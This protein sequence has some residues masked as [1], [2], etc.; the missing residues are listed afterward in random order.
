MVDEPI[1]ETKTAREELLEYLQSEVMKANRELQRITST[2]DQSRGE[3]EQLAQRNATIMGE[4]RRIEASVD[5]T[6]PL[7]IKE[8]YVEA[9]NSQQA[10]LTMRC[11]MEKLQTQEEAVQGT[12]RSLQAAIDILKRAEQVEADSKNSFDAREMIFRV[13]DAQEEERERLAR[14]MHDGPAHSLTNFILQAEICEKLFSRNDTEKA[15]EELMN[16]KTS[17]RAS[18]Q[19][20]RDFIFDLRPM[21]LTDLGLVP[22]IKRY[23]D[24]FESKTGIETEFVLTGQDR[25]LPGYVEVLIFRGI[26]ELMVNARDHGEAD[27]IKVSLDIGPDLVRAVV[28]DNGRGFSS[29]SLDLDASGGGTLGL[30]AMKERL[31]LVGGSINIDSVSGQGATVEISLPIEQETESQQIEY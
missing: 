29:G 26:L 9:L 13:M 24:A 3:I 27:K 12:V 7:N 17:A 8:A 31:S 2:L 21:M 11:Q 30:R 19:R 5:Q 10:L 14:Q 1:E 4:V 28:E 25:R 16:L 20:V 23:Q 15:R 6:S 18:F 22:T